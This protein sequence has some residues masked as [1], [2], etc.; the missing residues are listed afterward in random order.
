MIQK[1]R[2]RLREQKEGAL[3]TTC[4]T[5]SS[6]R[7]QQLSLIMP[8]KK[9]TN[10]ITTEDEQTFFRKCDFKL[11]IFTVCCVL[12]LSTIINF[13]SMHMYIADTQTCRT[14]LK[15]ESTSSAFIRQGL[16]RTSFLS[17]SVV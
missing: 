15:Q 2:S 3:V 6:G 12:S 7:D 13:V 9:E 14:A 17:N 1:S 16:A 4:R 5:L 8:L 10:S 11:F